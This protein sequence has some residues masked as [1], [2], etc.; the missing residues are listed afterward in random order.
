MEFLS[1]E[2]FFWRNEQRVVVCS[3]MLW[4]RVE[5]KFETRFVACHCCAIQKIDR[6][7]CVLL[8]ACDFGSMGVLVS[9]HETCVHLMTERWFGGW[10][11]RAL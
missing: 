6:G 2:L 3:R 5:S 8:F 9:E 1:F 4:A 10:V 11:V 7:K